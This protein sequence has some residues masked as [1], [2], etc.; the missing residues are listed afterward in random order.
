MF[1]AIGIQLNLALTNSTG[2]EQAI[3]I[4]SSRAIDQTECSIK[5]LK[6]VKWMTNLQKLK[7]HHGKTLKTPE[8]AVRTD[9][10]ETKV[11]RK[12]TLWVS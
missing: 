10:K 1:S 9:H 3:H 12:H 5:N 7:N 6:F 8:A 11:M 2:A 4:L